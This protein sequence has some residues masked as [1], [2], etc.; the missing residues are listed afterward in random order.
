MKLADIFGHRPLLK[1]CVLA[2]VIGFSSTQALADIDPDAL[3]VPG[4]IIVQFVPGAAASQIG[5]ANRANPRSQMR[6]AR[7]WVMEVEPGEELEVSANLRN[8][9]NVTF[10]EPNYIYQVIPCDTGDCTAPDNVFFG[11]KWDLH[12]TGYVVDYDGNVL[13]ETGQAGAD[14]AWLEAYEYLNNSGMAYD[15]IRL[16]VIDTGVRAS[17]HALAGKIAAQ[18]NFCPSFFCLIGAVNPD[19]YADDNGHGTHV[20]TTAAGRGDDVSGIPGVA[21]IDEV[22]IISGRVCGGALGLCNAAGVAN[23]IVWAVDEGADVLNLSLG[24]GAASTAQQNALQYAL[25]NNVLPVCA[26][27]N[28]GS[29]VVSYPAAFPE[30]MAVGSSNWSDERSSYSQGGAELEVVAPGGD[31]SDAQPHSLILAGWHTADNAYAYAAGT[32][33][34]SPQVAGLAALLRATG[35]TSAAAVRARIRETADD[36]GAPGW[37]ISFGDGRINAY[38]ALTGMDPYIEFDMSLRP[39]INAGANGNL[40]VVLYGREAETFS[41]EQLQVDSI[42]LGLTPLARRPNGTPFAVF[43]DNNEDGWTDLV[44]HFRVPELAANG[45]LA[46]DSITLHATLDD[47]RRLRAHMDID[48]H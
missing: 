9:P 7:T 19:A 1:S 17:H 18:R 45:D 3:F 2:L 22:G 36:L 40:Q 46:Y 47:G 11:N 21:W 5:A 12:N 13:A 16:G 38:R 8:N 39:S 48:V 25:A 42:L 37:D 24:G 43:T 33:M 20:A 30:C 14:L 35:M 31:V 41:L 44:M 6:L 23:A 34:A 28:D 29:N 32:S 10:A 26:S 27:G 15:N 4:E